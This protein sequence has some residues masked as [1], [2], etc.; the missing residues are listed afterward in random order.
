MIA[1]TH[2]KFVALNNPKCGSTSIR[3]MLQR[4]C[5][6]SHETNEQIQHHM[7]YRKASIILGEMDIDIS[8]YYVFTTTRNPWDRVVSA[9]HYGQRNTASVW[10]KLLNEAEGDFNRF[11]M[12]IGLE[13]RPLPPKTFDFA[14]DHQRNLRTHIFMMEHMNTLTQEIN[15]RFGLPIDTIHENKSERGHHNKYFNAESR[16]RIA[17]IYHIEAA[18]FGYTFESAA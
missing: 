1:S 17:E 10:H 7:N 18:V 13:G 5:D 3:R 16:N 2:Y 12:L 14:V 4:H 9:F 6:I 15:R 8:E 11:A